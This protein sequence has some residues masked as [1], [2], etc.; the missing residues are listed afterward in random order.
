MLEKLKQR[1]LQ[2]QQETQ[3][4]TVEEKPKGANE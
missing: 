1:E 2:Q 4:P 3:K